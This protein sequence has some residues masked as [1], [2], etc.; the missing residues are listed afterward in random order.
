PRRLCRVSTLQL[1]FDLR[2]ELRAG[3]CFSAAAT[4][5]LPDRLV[6][7]ASVTRGNR[8]GDSWFCHTSAS[9]G[10]YARVRTTVIRARPIC[11]TAQAR[12]APRPRPQ[13]RRARP[14]P[15]SAPPTVCDGLGTCT[16]LVPARRCRCAGLRR[17]RAGRWNVW[18]RAL[19][20][21]E[22]DRLQ[23]R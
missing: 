5:Q 14:T 6:V 16:H 23:L 10:D 2:A 3:R 1:G 7:S 11:A 13:A 9:N 4:R 22:R 17:A 15:P 18:R 8:L 12:A 20:E 19:L 21:R